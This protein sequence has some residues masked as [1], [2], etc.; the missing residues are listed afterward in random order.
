MAKKDA[1]CVHGT[2]GESCRTC[3]PLV[4]ILILQDCPVCHGISEVK[5]HVTSDVQYNDKIYSVPCAKCLKPPRQRPTLKFDYK[6]KQTPASLGMKNA[7]S[8]VD[9]DIY[10][11]WVMNSS[12]QQARDTSE[13]RRLL[14]NAPELETW[15]DSSTCLAVRGTLAGKSLRELAK[16]LNVSP[17]QVSNLVKLGIRKLKER[18]AMAIQRKEAF[19]IQ[20][21]A[22]MQMLFADNDPW[23]EYKRL[24]GSVLAAEARGESLANPEEEDRPEPSEHPVR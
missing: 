6:K 20:F 11:D 23:E 22:A 13:A 18:K 14:S 2:A 12:R 9:A 4:E 1:F 17:Q 16:E 15:L 10:I 5:I 24:P 21:D 19:S 8:E 7:M 3:F